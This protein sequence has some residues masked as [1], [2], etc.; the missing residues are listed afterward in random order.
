MQH[1]GYRIMHSEDITERDI[2]IGWEELDRRLLNDKEFQT[3]LGEDWVH[4]AHRQFLEEA[5]K[6]RAGQWGNGRIVA[7][8]RAG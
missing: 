3:V 2:E 4:D 5:C 7:A 1:L 6:M 8:K